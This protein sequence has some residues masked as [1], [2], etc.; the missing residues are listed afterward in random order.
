MNRSGWGDKW[1]AKHEINFVSFLESDGNRRYAGPEFEELL[2]MVNTLLSRWSF[3]R[4]ISYGASMGGYVALAYAKQCLVDTVL[5]INP[6]PG[7]DSGITDWRAEYHLGEKSKVWVSPWKDKTFSELRDIRILTMYDPFQKI[8]AIHSA[9]I[10]GEKYIVPF[11]GHALEKHAFSIGLVSS[12]FKIALQ[13]KTRSDDQM[14]FRIAAKSRRKLPKYYLEM[15]ASYNSHLTPRRA[16]IVLA[17]AAMNCSGNPVDQTIFHQLR[18]ETLKW[19]PS[20][21]FREAIEVLRKGGDDT[22][23]Q[24]LAAL[25]EH[26]MLT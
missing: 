9:F 15:S 25:V 14:A 21:L 4:R 19:V 18:T 7:Q 20:S 2:Q 5:A 6:I 1:C 11:L 13:K 24:Y 3:P 23:R 12:I 26:D 22:D 8:D 16:G 17:H 10:P